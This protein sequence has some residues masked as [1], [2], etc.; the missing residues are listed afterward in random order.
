MKKQMETEIVIRE[1]IRKKL[2]LLPE[3]AVDYIYLLENSKR[4]RTRHEYVKDMM[5]F[6]NFLVLSG[7]SDKK[8]IKDLE[9]ADLDQ[10]KD[11]DLIDFFDYLTSYEKTYI[12]PTGKTVVQKFTNDSVGK[13]RKLATLRKLFSYLFK[14]KLISKDITPSI[15][16]KVQQKKKISN[17]LKPEEIQLFFST[18]MDDMQIES[19][20]QLKFHE[21]VKFRDYIISLLLA[22][23]GIRVSELVQLDISDIHIQ[24][25]FL[26]VIRKGGNEQEITMPE[27]IIDDIRDYVDYRKQLTD[28][29]KGSRNALFISLHKKRIDQK[30]IRTFLEKYRLRSGIEIKITP[31]VFRRTFGTNHYNTYEDMYLTA[32]ILGHSSAETTRKFYADPSQERVVRSMQEYDYS[33][34]NNQEK[35]KQDK[36][37]KLAKKLGM[38]AS[39]LLKELS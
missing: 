27:R 1:Q 8:D 28:V 38:S 35:T 16:I 24:R 10:L 22:Y 19:T 15:E 5:L 17:R 11:R 36:I 31:H 12:S 26:V 21:K 32:E 33:F 18:I 23:T 4:I 30:T 39:D 29:E 13:S 37:E 3:F 25:K 20:R 7:K 14:K 9:P 6:F 34:S 2:L